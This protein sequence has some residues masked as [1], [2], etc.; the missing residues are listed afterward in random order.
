MKS[1]LV[2]LFLGV[3]IGIFTGGCSNY[4]IAKDT[5][6]ITGKTITFNEQ[7]EEVQT[8]LAKYSNQPEVMHQID[9]WQQKLAAALKGEVNTKVIKDL[10]TSASYLYEKCYIEAKS[11]WDELN[12]EQRFQLQEL[13]SM[14][15]STKKDIQEYLADPDTIDTKK[16][17]G[18]IG[19][20]VYYGFKIAE[21]LEGI[22]NA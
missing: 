8:E 20:V 12:T 1:L 18:D 4:K 3:L 21:K 9:V 22:H 7:V 6:K 17:L 14:A 15:L 5:V 10:Y 11:R 16:L 2:V 13:N 19:D